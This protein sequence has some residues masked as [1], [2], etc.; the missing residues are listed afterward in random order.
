MKHC[1]ESFSCTLYQSNL[2]YTHNY[3]IWCFC[4]P[5]LGFFPQI[6]TN[7]LNALAIDCKMHKAKI[8]NTFLLRCSQQVSGTSWIILARDTATPAS[9][10]VTA[11]ASAA[12]HCI[13]STATVRG[14]KN[15]VNTPRLCRCHCVPTDQQHSSPADHSTVPNCEPPVVSMYT[16][17]EKSTKQCSF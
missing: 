13:M 15:T 14:S 17:K 1:W 2:T 3:F 16:I 8:N 9:P 4:T 6:V 10:R 5:L 12:R 11:T 7:Y